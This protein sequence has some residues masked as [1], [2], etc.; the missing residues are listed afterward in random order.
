[1][2]YLLWPDKPVQRNNEWLDAMLLLQYYSRIAFMQTSK[3]SIVHCTPIGNNHQCSKIEGPVDCK[4]TG[5][6]YGSDCQ[7]QESTTAKYTGYFGPPVAPYIL[8]VYI[9]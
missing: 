6:A 7:R 8:L 9:D 1:M 2:D 3:S 5:Y 4:E